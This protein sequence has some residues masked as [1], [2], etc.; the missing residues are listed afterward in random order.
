MHTFEL[1]LSVFTA[2][3]VLKNATPE[4]LTLSLI[5]VT[6]T[7]RPPRCNRPSETL[8]SGFIHSTQ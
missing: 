6:L 2:D 1:C 8:L 4:K 5:Q 7:N 3:L